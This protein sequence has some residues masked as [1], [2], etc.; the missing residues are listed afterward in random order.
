MTEHIGV[1]APNGSRMRCEEC[2]SEAIVVKSEAPTFS[3]C[4]KPLT[5]TFQP[6]K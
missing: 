4:G 1:A 3:C 2:G 5:I 6:G